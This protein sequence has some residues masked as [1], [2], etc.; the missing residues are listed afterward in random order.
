MFFM[1]IGKFGYLS[2]I[3]L[4]WECSILVFKWRVKLGY[5]KIIDD[6]VYFFKVLR[7]MYGMFWLDIFVI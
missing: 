1:S 2:I 7:L 5:L 4:C 6:I 3:C